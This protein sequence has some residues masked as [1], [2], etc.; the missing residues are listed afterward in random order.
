[1]LS[2]SSRTDW[3]QDNN[4]S[5]QTEMDFYSCFHAYCSHPCDRKCT[6]EL[7]SKLIDHVGVGWRDGLEGRSHRMMTAYE[8]SKYSKALGGG[9]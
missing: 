5:S 1:M 4:L 3:S 2:A 8:S 7:P 6:G 9:I